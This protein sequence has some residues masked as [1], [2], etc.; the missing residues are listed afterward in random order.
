MQ[1]VVRR[2]PLSW[3]T[4]CMIQS[5]QN[6]GHLWTR[7][8]LAHGVNLMC[9]P[10]RVA[11]AALACCFRIIKL[12]LQL[13]IV[14]VIDRAQRE[15]EREEN[16]QKR[17]LHES[18]ESYQYSAIVELHRQHNT[19]I[20]FCVIC[21]SRSLAFVILSALGVRLAFCQFEWFECG[22]SLTLVY[23]RSHLE[24]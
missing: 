10:Y 11:A 7:H 14:T 8:Y 24:N 18:I 3:V 22:V 6:I 17:Q 19:I 12:I 15:R 16:S 20:K 23:E 2:C 13:N 4:D 21:R 9:W 1:F 5:N